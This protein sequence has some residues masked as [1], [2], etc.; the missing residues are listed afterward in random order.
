MLKKIIVT[1]PM[2]TLEKALDLPARS[3]FGEGGAEPLKAEHAH[4]LALL[5]LTLG[6][7]H[8]YPYNLTPAAGGTPQ[9]V[10][11]VLVGAVQCNNE[12]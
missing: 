4:L 3:R 6:E 2:E 1:D 7:V 12:V 8:S 11:S 10:G 5:N 9:G